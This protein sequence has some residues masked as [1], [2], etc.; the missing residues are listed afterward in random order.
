MKV[1]RRTSPSQR[2]AAPSE[3]IPDVFTKVLN[4]IL[5]PGTTP[6]TPIES[7]NGLEAM[8]RL[9]SMVTAPPAA[10]TLPSEISSN[11]ERETCT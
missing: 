9:F 4:W 3:G 8:K 7:E 11:V 6:L 5:L 2:S 10:S 1:P